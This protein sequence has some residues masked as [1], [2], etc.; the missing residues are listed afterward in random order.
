MYNTENRIIYEMII[1]HHHIGPLPHD[2]SCN[3]QLS[4]AWK[5]YQMNDISWHR[6]SYSLVAATRR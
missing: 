4:N 3:C 1:Y 5:A 6:K 2:F